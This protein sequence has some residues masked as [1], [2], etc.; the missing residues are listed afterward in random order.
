MKSLSDHRQFL[1]LT[2]GAILVLPAGRFLVACGSE[3]DYANSTDD[4]PAAA[5]RA[6]GSGV[7][8]SSS[9][10]QNHFHTFTIEDRHVRGATVPRRRRGH[11]RRRRS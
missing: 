1:R 3:E 2:A 6:E 7:V 4:V 10:V 5:P 9:S 11:E 8:Y